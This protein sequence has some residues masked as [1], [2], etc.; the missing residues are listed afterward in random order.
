MEKLAREDLFTLEAY[1]RSR[2][3]FR[4][5][6]LNHKKSRQLALGPHATLYFEDRLTVQ[7]QIQEMLRTERI[8]E[9][10]G[11]EEE[12]EAYNPL[13]PDGENLMATLMLEYE[14]TEERH[15]ALSELVGIED[16][17]WLQVDG[18]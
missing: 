9:A 11:I 18:H 6:V 12:L 16:V 1:A 5:K 13:I 7:Y 14:D 10:A 3:D 17:V 8:F 15:I 2:P 4:A